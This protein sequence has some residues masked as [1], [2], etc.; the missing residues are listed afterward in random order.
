MNDIVRSFLFQWWI[1]MLNFNQLKIKIEHK[2]I[3]LYEQLI[4]YDEDEM[5]LMQYLIFFFPL[6][7]N[8]FVHSILISYSN[9]TVLSFFLLHQNNKMQ[10]ILLRLAICI[11]FLFFFKFMMNS[12]YFYLQDDLFI[13]KN[14]NHFIILSKI[15][16]NISFCL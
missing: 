3:S 8:S 5:K 1:F 13:R 10:H 9:E 14:F 15:L 11:L 7:Y 4:D 16:F 12:D 6:L 2:L